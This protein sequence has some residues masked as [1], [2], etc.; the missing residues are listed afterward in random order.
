MYAS[1]SV[2]TV[3]SEKGKLGFSPKIL[4]CHAKESG[5]DLLN[6]EGP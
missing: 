6:K 4:M 1:E 2:K 3:D 5:F